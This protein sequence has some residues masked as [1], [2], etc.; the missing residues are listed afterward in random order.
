MKENMNKR[1]ALSVVALAIM[2]LAADIIGECE[3]IFPEVAALAVGLWIADKRIWNVKCYEIPTIMTASAVIGVI[4]TTYITLPV[5]WQLTLA[6]FISATLMTVLNIPLIP[7]IAAILLP[8]LLHTESWFYPASVAV[9]TTIMAAGQAGMQHWGLKSKLTPVA[10]QAVTLS[11]SLHLWASRYGLLLPLL[12]VATWQGWL[13]AIVPPLI[14][15]LIELSNPANMFR[16]R[17]WTLWATVVIVATI[18]TASRFF[19]M[20]MWSM[21]YVVAVSLSFLTAILLMRKVK[22][23]FPP[24]PALAV[25]PFILPDSYMM[26]PVEAAVGGAYVIAVPLLAGKI[27][28][29]KTVSIRAKK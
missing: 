11:Q 2:A 27:L 5:F 20:Q 6:F 28:K 7:S 9:M 19:L 13:F 16:N 26:F 17:P 18:G 1:M 3:V 24:I 15:I 25:I 8:V 29:P 4:I 12:I 21:P 10:R 23:M 14:I 22:L